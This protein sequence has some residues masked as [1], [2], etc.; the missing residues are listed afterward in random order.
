MFVVISAR[1]IRRILLIVFL[2]ALALVAAYTAVSWYY[3]LKY[4]DI[5]E[6]NCQK[7]QLEP[8]L[9]CAVIHAE[10]KFNNAARSRKGASGLMQIMESTADWAAEEIGLENFTYDQI[11]EPEI[12]IQIGCW[13]LNRLE[14][15]FGS[16]EQAVCAYNAGSGNVSKWLDNPR[17]S[18]DGKH[19][20]VI[21]FPETEN[22]IKRV[23]FNQTVYDVILRFFR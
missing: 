3:P 16:I 1:K 15:Q 4:I 19:L 14:K 18:R 8:D 22:Y 9:V 20:D 2:S 10:S 23:R 17:Y 5:I 7:Y 21:P 6:N 13:L 12:N 11:F